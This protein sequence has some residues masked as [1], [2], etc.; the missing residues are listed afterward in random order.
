MGTIFDTQ[1]ADGYS[2]L[3]AQAR[4]LDGFD[5]NPRQDVWELRGIGGRQVF[6]FEHLFATVTP[7][8]LHGY[9]R[10]LLWALENMAVGTCNLYHRAFS[11]TISDLAD[12]AAA[13]GNSYVLSEITA[14]EVLDMRVICNARNPRG[15]RA[16]SPLLVKWSQLGYAGIST[17]IAKKLENIGGDKVTN[18]N[19]VETLCPL[20]GPLSAME[21]D[22]F[23]SKIN[24]S[25]ANGKLSAENYA[26]LFLLR[27]F[28]CRPAQLSLL[29][30]K[31]VIRRERKAGEYEHFIAMPSVKRGKV[32]RSGFKNRLLS[33]DFGAFLYEMKRKVE[34]QYTTLLPDPTLAP[35]FGLR[36]VRD[37]EFLDGLEYHRS[38]A[39]MSKYIA[40]LAGTIGCISERTGENMHLNAYRFRYTKGTAMAEEGHSQAIIAE[41]LDHTTLGSVKHYTAVT[42]KF[43]ARYNKALS[44]R[45]ATTAQAFAGVLI[46]SSDADAGRAIRSP[47]ITGTFEPIARCGKF[48]FC[49][50]NAP[51]ACYTCVSFRPFKEAPHEVILD[52]LL[53]E[54]E[55]YLSKSDKTLAVTEDRTIVAI[56]QVVLRCTG[57]DAADILAEYRQGRA[58]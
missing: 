26:L 39:T 48:G 30:T 55:R 19:P 11:D 31:D 38:S 27:A 54:R 42:G 44:M 12:Y 5:F 49:K 46:S 40:Y 51:I 15:W 32:H 29:K 20:T 14:K 25:F 36:D 37:D 9:K 3:P 58:Q 41:A 22:E 50:F 33:D 53:R 45:L 47:E 7:D 1:E 24:E 13:D 18:A 43:H 28:G 21:R 34:G 17:E 35:L 57:R 4:T 56:A 23:D 2:V 10:T 6:R 52:Y 16:L 8:V